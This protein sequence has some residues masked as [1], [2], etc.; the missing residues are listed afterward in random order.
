MRAY[1]QRAAGR[2][3]ALVLAA[4]AAGRAGDGHKEY[5]TWTGR[6]GVRM[7]AALAGMQGETVTLLTREGRT[8]TTRCASLSDPDQAYLAERRQPAAAAGP[9][10][11]AVVPAAP[12]PPA[13]APAAAGP[14]EGVDALLAALAGEADLEQ[15]ADLPRRLALA[16]LQSGRRA[17]GR[18]AL[19][20]FVI[21]AY[22]APSRLLRT[23][24]LEIV[25]GG[26]DAAALLGRLAP[27]DAAPP[28]AEVVAWL[29]GDGS[30]LRQLADVLH[31][32]DDAA[33]AVAILQQL[34]DHDPSGRET[35][36]KLM[37][38]MAVV[39]DQPRRPLHG[40]MGSSPPAFEAAIDQRYDFFRALYGTP[41]GRPR[42]E[43][44]DA[45]TLRFVVDTPVPVAEL[46]WARDHVS[47]SV[48]GWS[49][50]FS[51]IVYD[52]KRFEDGVLTWPHGVY[53][54][55]AIRE[56][57]GICVD[58][59][60]YAALSARAN[61]IPALFFS[62]VGRRGHHAWFAYLKGK[63]SW[64]LDV[65]RYTYDKYATGNAVD[66]QTNRAMTDHD[67]EYACDASLNSCQY[68]TANTYVRIAEI[69]LGGGENEAA[70]A[71][72]GEARL[73]ARRYERPWDIEAAALERQKRLEEAVTLLDEKARFFANYPDM[74][75]ATRR[76]QAELL[77]KLGR[78]DDAAA[79]LNREA[80][81][82]R[83]ERDDLAQDL[84]AQQADA[85]LQ[86]GDP[87][88]ARKTMEK[89]LRDRIGEGQKVVGLIEQY[90]EMT[91]K[92][93]Q[94]AAAAEFMEGYTRQLINRYA[95]SEDTRRIA[96]QLLLR[97]YR[98]AGDER[99]IRKTE[100]EIERIERAL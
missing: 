43:A 51:D 82:M 16:C 38:A 74:A 63:S 91:L 72:A 68:E 14:P 78:S 3:F 76:R 59:A 83:G 93:R 81:R 90:L 35:Y 70:R 44:L 17:D 32:D 2:V 95:R 85:S 99:G 89:L 65:G 87:E 49:E 19:V 1:A 66:P 53:T 8:V 97:A 57:G 11:P 86:A 7:E 45:A 75:I 92:S 13:A 20:R 24:K 28:R 33:S 36:F 48:S 34:Y 60:Y 64:E 100:R 22:K 46:E 18:E 5:R 61:G 26:A 29:L 9:P 58:Q 62:G 84:V 79:L 27:L 23:R 73:L 67:V 25:A 94:T 42:Y 88:T 71:C 80:R 10:T 47:G 56:K 98:N 41:S 77:E 31:P 6:N 39:W 50:K 30:R 55:A 21:G 54:L 40:Q 37:L 12:A 69:L 52:R 96:L 4:A 15:K